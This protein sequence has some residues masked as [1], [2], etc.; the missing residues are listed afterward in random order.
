MIKDLELKL[1][2]SL[3][4]R[5]EELIELVNSWGKRD[6]MNHSYINLKPKECYNLSNL[7]VSKIKDFSS[8][9]RCSLYNGDLSKWDVSNAIT[10]E[11]M[12]AFSDFNS[13]LDSWNVSNVKTMDFMFYR[14]KF[15]NDSLND[16]N[17]SNVKFMNSILE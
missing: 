1:S 6:S 13:N 10:M 14:S 15:N 4:I 7:D 2:G 3:P 8:V 17:V 16:W 12:F 11:S 9:L 5:R